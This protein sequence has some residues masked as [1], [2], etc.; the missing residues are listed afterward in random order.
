MPA[1]RSAKHG[2][3]R[4]CIET[5]SSPPL[6]SSC[7]SEHWTTQ[8][9]QASCSL[10]SQA[11]SHQEWNQRWSRA[12]STGAGDPAAQHAADSTLDTRSP[13]WVHAATAMEAAWPTQQRVSKASQSPQARAINYWNVFWSGPSSPHHPHQPFVTKRKKRGNN[14]SQNWENYFQRESP[15]ADRKNFQFSNGFYPS[16]NLSLNGKKFSPTGKTHCRTGKHFPDGKNPS[17]CHRT[18]KNFFQ[19]EFFFS[20]EKASQNGKISAQREGFTCSCSWL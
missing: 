15:V 9:G 18:G 17:H 1:R 6:D 5:R 8:Q 16:Q 10:L 2:E 3:G 11:D 20:W 7:A 13:G 14:Q 4:L 12:C 19:R